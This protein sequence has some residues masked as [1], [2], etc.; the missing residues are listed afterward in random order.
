MRSAV[1]LMSSS[2]GPGREI[3]TSQDT[4]VVGAGKVAPGWDEALVG[5]C[6]GEEVIDHPE[7][8]LNN[9]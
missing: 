3:D 6:E 4:V 2:S 5:V 9:I 7:R 8:I 1:R